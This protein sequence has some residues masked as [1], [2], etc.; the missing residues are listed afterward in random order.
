MKKSSIIHTF[1]SCRQAKNYK[2]SI[3]IALCALMLVACH[4]KP[5]QSEQDQEQQQTE[6]SINNQQSSINK[7]IDITGVTLEGTEFSL[8]EMVGQSDYVLLDF[9]ATWCHPCRQLMP[10]LYDIY[11][12]YGGDR[13]EILSCSLDKE[14]APWREYLFETRFP[15]QQIRE[16]ANH[17]CADKY[18]VQYIPHTI[19][20]DKEGN[21]VAV[22]IEEPD[23]EAILLGE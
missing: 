3:I 5:A 15:W 10:V 1:R 11:L 4:K 16:D 12:R 7:Y 21:I 8:S 22:D 19:L 18:N 9:W 6:S 14:D 23:L 17:P 13:F 2:S 20:I